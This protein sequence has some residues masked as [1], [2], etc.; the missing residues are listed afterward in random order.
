MINSILKRLI[1]FL[2]L[3]LISLFIKAQQNNTLFLMHDLPQANIVNP[4]L[5]IDC[6]YFVALP[7]IGS[8]HTNNISNGFSFDDIFYKSSDDSLRISLD[9]IVNNLPIKNLISSEEHLQII[10]FGYKYKNNYFTFGIQEKSNLYI[11]LP[12]K[13]LQLAV[14]GN[15]QFE[16]DN[17]NLNNV[18]LEALHYR[19]YAF[20]W[21]SQITDNFRFGLKAKL[22][23][24]KAAIKT[25]Y[26]KGSLYTDFFTFEDY[27]KI[28][29]EYEMSAPIDFKTNNRN[30][31]TGINDNFDA[32]PYFM[33]SKNVGA[34][35]DLGFVKYF[36][37]DLILS[38]SVL[39]L[40]FVSWKDNLKKLSIDNS[41]EFNSEGLKTDL[42]NYTQIKDSITSAMR[43]Y[44]SEGVFSST[45]TPSAY[46]GL[47]KFV[48]PDFNYGAVIHSVFYKSFMHNSITFVAN[49]KLFKVFDL[50]ASYTIQNREFDNLGFGIGVTLGAVHFY[51]VSDNVVGLTKL[52]DTRNVNFRAGVGLLF[53]CGGQIKKRNPIGKNKHKGALPCF[54]SPYKNYNKIGR[55]K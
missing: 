39:N 51:A 50:S 47:T 4:A 53:G 38:G 6:K 9:N 34:A 44:L 55:K 11:I 30:Q 41:F 19:E 8:I 31:V 42:N 15:S 16:G 1:G 21:A 10:G 37:S 7:A 46:L 40:G 2:L 25:N 33:N 45:L 48:S 52:N 43:P 32:M 24:G 18:M 27:L 17:I 22:L 20:G 35:I 49:K 28:D 29:A 13:V 5:D 26:F 14:N 36:N 23:F 3:S 54:T 12:K